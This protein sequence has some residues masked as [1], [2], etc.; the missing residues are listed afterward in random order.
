[1]S[2]TL[3]KLIE[4]WCWQHSAGDHPPLLLMSGA[5]GVGKSTALTWLEKATDGHVAI[6]GI[7]DF[8]LTAADRAVLARDIH[9]L[10]ATRGPAGTHDLVLLHQVLDQLLD[11]DDTAPI[12]VPVFDK[13][14]DDR[15]PKNAWRTLH[16]APR[17]VILEGWL[18]GA[19]PDLSAPGD[20]PLNLVEAEDPEG[21]WRAW[22]EAHLSEDYS[23]LWDR[24]GAFLH[25][26]APSFDV[27]LR[28]RIQQEE[29]TLGFAPGTLPPERV[30][31]VAR[32][33]QHYE[34]VTRRMLAGNRRPGTVIAV[35]EN[36]VP[37]PF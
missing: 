35:D 20:P 17:A 16:A 8:Y 11:P 18:M 3:G 34:R 19:E 27:V 33:I 10:C 23:A 24:A 14:L 36:R 6:L 1:M 25:L 21:V 5:Q 22:Q 26:D 28:W 32:F 12:A 9:P 13:A 37:S 15:A 29:G 30:A 2:D 7:D 31:W 4:R